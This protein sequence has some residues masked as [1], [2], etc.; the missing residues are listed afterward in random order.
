MT[1]MVQIWA[2]E[3]L[4]EIAPGSDLAALVLAAAP[5]LRDGDILVVSSKIVSKAEGRTVPAGD[6]EL[7]LAGETV[8]MVAS[9]DTARGPIRI[10]ENRLGIVAA[11][12][13]IDAS[14]TQEGTLLLLPV[15]P[16]A[17]ALAL[18][19]AFRRCL[20]VSIG[21]VISDTL[22]RAWRVGQTDAAIG[23][24]GLKVTQDLRGTLD[25][26]G[27]RLEASIAAVADEI[28]SAADLVKGKA[29]GRPVAVVRGLGHLVGALDL[30]GARSL[31]RPADEDMFRKGSEE[32]F[33]DG[34]A[35]GIAAG[36]EHRKPPRA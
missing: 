26:G 33:A 31:V 1:G 9:R 29:A 2:L 25:A 21:I 19:A 6:R 28:A 4:P 11:N 15:D 10:V 34:Y 30:P 27:R 5:D 7:A 35:A 20:G 18:A 8:R 36:I 3:G 13:G 24:A 12:A 22:G 16:D 23:A 17:S 14:N 32:A